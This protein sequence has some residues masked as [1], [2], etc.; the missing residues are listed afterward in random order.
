MIPIKKKI[1]QPEEGRGRKPMYP[2]Y[3]MSI[4]D[5][6]EQPMDKYYT[7]ARAAHQHAKRHGVK[8]RIRKIDSKK[9]GVWRV[10]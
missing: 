3:E 1:K 9:C 10:A 4:G 7:V 2:F 6:F 8:M 5:M